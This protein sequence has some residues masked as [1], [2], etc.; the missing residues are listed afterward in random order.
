VGPT[1]RLLSRRRVA[2][3][4]R[5]EV[6]GG[7]LDAG[8]GRRA[9]APAAILAC[10]TA[11]AHNGGDG[12]GAERGEVDSALVLVAIGDLWQERDQDGC[13]EGKA[14]RSRRGRK[15]PCSDG[16]GR[17]RDDLRPRVER[18]RARASQTRPGHTG[19][20]FDEDVRPRCEMGV[21]TIIQK[22]R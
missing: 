21:Y 15:H 5:W 13:A 2:R 18:T 22:Y 11:R 12:V 8:S 20:H 1:G 9:G 10:R 14:A 3:R 4:R 7:A 16:P 6:T 17:W 19:G